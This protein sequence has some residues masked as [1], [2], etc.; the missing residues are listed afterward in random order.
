MND[1]LG[2]ESGADDGFAPAAKFRIK[3]CLEALLD[4][5][6]EMWKRVDPQSTG[7]LHFPDFAELMGKRVSVQQMKHMFEGVQEVS[8]EFDPNIVEG[9]SL[10]LV[11]A[12]MIEYALERESSSEHKAFRFAIQKIIVEGQATA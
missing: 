1:L 8:K 3:G 4:T 12:K 9:I 6:I 2:T 5:M 7:I 11:G 10:R